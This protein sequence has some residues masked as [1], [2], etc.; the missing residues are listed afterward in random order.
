MNLFRT[1]SE[2][3]P[4]LRGTLRRLVRKPGY[5]LAAWLMLGLAV[6]ANT[7]VFAIVYGFMLK[8]LPYAHP[9]QLS[10]VRERV[11][12]I[13][14]NT[15]LVSVETYLTLKHEL[16]DI[17]DAGL[18]TNSGN[19]D[20]AT[21]AGHRHLLIFQKVTPS[22]FRTLGVQPV[23]G[24]LPAASAGRPGG[25]PEAVI[26]W[27]FW[28]SAYGGR[29]N[30]LGRSFEVGGTSY[31]IVGIM[32][33]SF[34]IQT[35]DR[36]A[37]LP[38]VITSKRAQDSNINYWMMVRR[39]PGVSP[40]DLNLDLAAVLHRILDRETPKQRAD[41][42]RNGYVI[43]ARSPHAVGLTDYSSVGRLP[44][45]L[46]AAAGL[47]LLLAL[48][49]TVNLGLVR[50]RARQHE[51]ALRH[52]LGSSRLALVRLILVEHLPILVAV[53]ATATL[54]AWAA[55][56]TL[57]AFGLPRAFSPF[58]V[59]LAPAVIAFAWIVAGLA[60]FV[61]AFGPAL[62]AAGRRLLTTLGNGPTATG[63]KGPRRVQRTLGVVQVAFSCALVIAG[64]LL[65]LSLWRILSQPNGFATKHRI[66]ATIVAPDNVTSASAA[67]AAL[68][69][70]LLE[71]PGVRR[72]A[73]SS[74]APFT[75]NFING[76]VSMVG[77]DRTI[78]SKMPLVSADFFSTLGVQFVAGRPFTAGEI[79]NRAPV[80]VINETLAKQFFGSAK[81]AV[82]QSLQMLGKSRVIG[83][84]RDIR[85]APTPGRHARGTAYLPIGA[86]PGGSEVI[87]QARG[88][89]APLM[90]TLRRTIKAALPG[91]VIF[92]MRALPAMMRGA[93]VFRAAGAGMV[94]TFAAL[95]LVLAALGVFAITAFIARARLGEYGIRAALGAGPA[96]LLRL[97]FG[98]A[99][100]LLL[101]GLPI[102]LGGA[103]LLGR[104]IASA[105]Y[106]TP[107]LSPGLYLAGAVVIA[108]VVI[109]AA[110]GPAR[111]AAHTPVR[112]L[113]GGGSTH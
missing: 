1:L 109:A 70:A 25:P 26:S 41:D 19:D 50:Q 78:H 93:A 47:L 57:H 103:Y 30:V 22:L 95:A 85:W 12:K 112:D 16:G 94:G 59:T 82:G 98:E 83:V 9:G 107:I 62:L 69:P 28:H 75:G 71:I 77:T 39:K 102:G 42:I 81:K 21:V 8:P 91:T 100:W 27:Q 34:F 13:G 108:A 43:D 86:F 11:T 90:K 2:S 17:A 6:A 74:M 67:W 24:R 55:A 36:D 35:G 38:F 54:L 52:V 20:I 111:R 23:L 3:M 29:P 76:D 65:G 89:T 49:N 45:L 58:H 105:L 61:V 48:A 18:A 72:T 84:T 113:I 64:G 40:H 101:I 15:P 60:V 33:R 4:Y 87:V 37:W 104:V 68:K 53:G 73:F 7:A 10:T 5:A 32:P 88:A 106:R 110:W 66:V 51:F 31:R 44:W 96:A 80:M 92:R 46:Q 79:A 63:G 99:G 97:G 56:R 14:L